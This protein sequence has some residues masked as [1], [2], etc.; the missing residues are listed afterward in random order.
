MAMATNSAAGAGVAESLFDRLRFIEIAT[1]TDDASSLLWPCLE[2]KDFSS[3]TKDVKEAM[4]ISKQEHMEL[5]MSA[6]R[7]MKSK[8]GMQ[9]PVALLLGKTVPNQNRC[10]WL[11]GGGEL[12]SFLDNFM[13]V[14]QSGEDVAGL[15]DAMQVT[16]SIMEA[17]MSKDSTPEVGHDAIASL[18]APPNKSNEA[19]AVETPPDQDNALDAKPA[20]LDTKSSNDEEAIVP[21]KAA[22]GS[23]LKVDE[24]I[25][26]K[27][28][29]IKTEKVAVQTRN[30]R[31]SSSKR[32]S[33]EEAPTE[34]SIEPEQEVVPLTS[35]TRASS[36]R[37]R[38]KTAKAARVSM[39]VALKAEKTPQ[40]EQDLSVA[41]SSTTSSTLT[42]QTKH[43]TALK[44]KTP[45]TVALSGKKQVAPS[46]Q[47]KKAKTTV[48]SEDV[49]PS[50]E[51]VRT[52]LKK[53]DYVFRDGVY[54]RPGMDPT[55][56]KEAQVGEGYFKDE[57]AFRKYLCAYG[58]DGERNKWTEEDASLIQKWVRYTVV[59]SVS[60]EGGIPDN[61]PLAGAKATSFLKMLGFRFCTVKGVQD[62]YALPGVLKGEEIV[63]VN[64]FVD[65]QHGIWSHLA[66]FG[67]PENCY[68]HGFSDMDMLNLELYICCNDKIETL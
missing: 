32:S 12:L 37:K 30:T 28:T 41:D 18:D 20:A 21:Q 34:P 9:G 55:K 11:Q 17:A 48:S 33:K 40:S 65:G 42:R 44:R 15:T 7:R 51:E 14:V 68:L 67:L 56:N 25:A 13:A 53:G 29:F 36:S 47:S 5:A 45:P 26:P 54:C 35:K 31:A 39:D 1:G 60:G 38:P 64:C 59:K 62:V 22:T 4:H 10:V 50:F 19:T 6:V 3:I 58:V 24:V 27:E 2:F 57:Q 46:T 63:G 49:I 16:E 8:Q 23:L 66:R 61:E 43:S 52:S